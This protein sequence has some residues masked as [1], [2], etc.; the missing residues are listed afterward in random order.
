M[1][2]LVMGLMVMGLRPVETGGIDWSPVLLLSGALI[3]SGTLFG[4][5]LGA[6]RW[7]GAI[8]PLGGLGMIL[9]FG[10]FAWT[11]LRG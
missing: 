5:A 1:V 6:P 2:G 7:F 9:G 4:L 8:T 11:R 10:L 3:F